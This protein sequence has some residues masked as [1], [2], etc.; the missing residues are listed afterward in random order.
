MVAS[1]Y[2]DFILTMPLQDQ[3]RNRVMGLDLF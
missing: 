2:Q 1:Y 3:L